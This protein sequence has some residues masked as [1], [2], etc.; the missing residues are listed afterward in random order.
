MNSIKISSKIS[1]FQRFDY[2]I[3]FILAVIFFSLQSF[4]PFYTRGEAR[5]GLVINAMFQQNNFILPLRNGIDIPSKPPLF[6]WIAALIIYIFNAKAEYFYRIPSILSSALALSFFLRFF[7]KYL[8]IP[9]CYIAV[10]VLASS[11]EWLRSS[12]VAR[13]D[14]LFSSTLAVGLFLIF[15]FLNDYL[16]MHR[17]SL[18]KLLLISIILACSFLTK[19]PAGL[20][21]PWVIAFLFLVIIK[22]LDFKLISGIFLSAVITALIAGIWYFC[23]YQLVGEKFLEVSLMKENLARIVGNDDYETGHKGNFFSVFLLLI[24]GYFPWSLFFPLTFIAGLKQRKKFFFEKNYL[25]LFCLITAIFFLLFFGFVSSKRSVYLL[26]AYPALTYLFVWSIKNLNLENYLKLNKFTYYLFGVL[27]YLSSLILIA[28]LFLTINKNIPFASMLKEKDLFLIKQTLNSISSAKIV[29]LILLIIANRL[30][31]KLLILKTFKEKILQ[32]LT[33]IKYVFLQVILFS[34][35]ITGIIL[36]PITTQSSAKQF[37]NEI[38]TNFPQIKNIYQFHDDYY[39]AAFYFEKNI[40]RA[41]S[42]E[43]IKEDPAYLVFSKKDL[44]LARSKFEKLEVLQESKEYAIYG[45][46]KFI[47]AKV[48]K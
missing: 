12:C 1:F 31:I 6:H 41:D 25:A 46:D 14:L 42:P 4:F 17:V 30:L 39:I 33:L 37:F 35:F 20:V 44:N 13:V 40:P 2:L 22:K 43:E 9:F 10:L 8:E 19:G 48:E 16:K 28:M 34:I 7:K 32:M 18:S 36:W 21:L 24:T 47:L 11:M 15:D 3:I 38:K 27:F 23:S 26:P 5:E 29:L 45:K